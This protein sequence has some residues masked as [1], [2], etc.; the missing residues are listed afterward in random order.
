MVSE[1]YRLKIPLTLL[2]EYNGLYDTRYAAV[3][4]IVTV[5]DG[6]LDGTRIVEVIWNGETALMITAE[7]RKHGELLSQT[8]T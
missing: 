2:V 8:T 3:G 4:D 6:P 7:L 1:R 5:T